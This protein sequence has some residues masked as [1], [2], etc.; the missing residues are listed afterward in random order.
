MTAQQCVTPLN[1]EPVEIFQ[2]NYSGTTCYSNGVLTIESSGYLKMPNK[3]DPHAYFVWDVPD[4]VNEIIINANTIVNAGFHYVHELNITGLD[5]NTSIIYGT[6]IV[7]WNSIFDDG[8]FQTDDCDWIYISVWKKGGSANSHIKDITF[9]N[10]KTFAIRGFESLGQVNVSNCNFID[11]RDGVHNN[12]DGI[13]T[14]PNSTIRN[15]YFE[16][17]DD[18]IKILKPNM[19]VYDCTFNMVA[20]SVPFNIG[21]GSY[22][23]QGSMTASNIKI[24]GY[25]GRS[26]NGNP[27]IQ[28]GTWKSADNG[29]SE[30]TIT[31][32]NI[33]IDNPNASLVSMLSGNQCLKG[34][35]DYAN[36]QRING[37]WGQS[38]QPICNTMTLC[39]NSPG[40]LNS[41]SGTQWGGSSVSGYNIPPFVQNFTNEGTNHASAR[42]RDDVADVNNSPSFD[43]LSFCQ[44]DVT[45]TETYNTAVDVQV[46]NSI[47]ASNIINNGATV[48][49][50]AGYEVTLINGFHA[51]YGCDFDAFIDGCEAVDNRND[52]FIPDENDATSEVALRNYPNPFTGTTTIEYTLP[53]AQ[54]VS[55]TINNISGQVIHALK[56]NELQQS[57]LYEFQFDARHLPAGVY[58]CTLQTGTRLHVQKMI[59]SK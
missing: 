33:H 6:K 40:N 1:P 50:D 7:D 38:S 21:W 11:N 2:K 22:S 5:R 31:I 19:K 46:A 28:S 53:E 36:I 18:N 20:N 25:E 15:C 43:C 12:S 48:D 58:I 42:H 4:A 55:L 17:K 39:G 23:N 9:L 47:T 10:P 52:N 32:D 57:G 41:C 44:D 26:G 30:V 35:I 56:Q 49:Y 59:L 3:P 13:G 54:Q 45:I 51:R 34:R 16:T 27:I 8:N 14:G 29:N 37:Y 24:I